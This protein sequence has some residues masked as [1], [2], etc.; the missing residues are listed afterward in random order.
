MGLADI[1]LTPRQQKML[2]PLLLNPEQSYRLSELL[3]LSGSGRGA[4]QKHIDNFVKAGVLKEE[5]LG[6]QRCLK[7]NQDFPLYQD[8]RSICLKTFGLGEG[9]KAALEPLAN[10]ISEAFIFGSVASSTD[11]ADS[12]ID[13]MVI[14]SVPLIPLMDVIASVEKTLG[15]SIHVNLHDDSTWQD[16]L[17]SDSVIKQITDS[18]TIMIIHNAK[19]K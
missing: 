11:R 3:T 4:S 1:L 15:R 6:N 5:R 9:L 16:M 13:L 8:L 12:D 10:Q 7:I 17:A 18:P 14:G 19:T 2:T